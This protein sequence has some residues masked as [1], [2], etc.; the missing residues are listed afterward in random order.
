ME[1]FSELPLAQ[2]ILT[3]L[4]NAGYETPTPIQREA[5]PHLLE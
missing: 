5:I 1:K 3:N 4:E 2:I